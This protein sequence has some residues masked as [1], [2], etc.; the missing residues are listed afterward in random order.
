MQ[1]DCEYPFDPILNSLWSI[2]RF[3]E[4][5]AKSFVTT[6]TENEPSLEAPPIGFLKS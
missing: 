1:I 2:S 6:E 5:Q 4:H 3:L